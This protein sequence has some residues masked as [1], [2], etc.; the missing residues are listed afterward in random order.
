LG[1]GLG[2]GSPLIGSEGEVGAVRQERRRAKIKETIN[3]RPLATISVYLPREHFR[4]I[5]PEK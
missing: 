5:I 2:E 3:Q 4:H 1:R